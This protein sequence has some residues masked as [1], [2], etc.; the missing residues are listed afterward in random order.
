M[1]DFIRAVV[2]DDIHIRSGGTGR[3]VEAYAAVFD[4]PSEV[5]DQDGHYMERN[6]QGAFNQTIAHHAGRFPVIYH[7]GL[8]IAGTPS[9]RGSVPIGV[10]SEVKVDKR[11]VLTISEYGRSELADEVLEAI[12]LGAVTAQSYGGRFIKSDPRKPPNGFRRSPAGHLRTVTRLEVAMREFGP[13]PFPAFAGAA[14][15]GIRTQQLLGALL[16]TPAEHRGELLA[17]LDGISTPTGNEP[18]TEPETTEP[19]GT[20]DQP[21]TGPDGADEAEEAPAGHSARAIPL[22]TRIRAAR[23]ARGWE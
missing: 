16:T 2:L 14:I 13:T 11:G 1:T 21:A 15:T 20:P 5:I 7:H 22:A 12:R 9:E 10:S 4:D 18:G 23:I 19:L 6:A 8:T 3:T 17:Q